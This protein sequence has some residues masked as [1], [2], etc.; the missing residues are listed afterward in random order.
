MTTKQAYEEIEKLHSEHHN[1]L[2]IALDE[3]VAASNKDDMGAVKGI[4]R[5]AHI[6]SGRIRF[7]AEKVMRSIEEEE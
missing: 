4:G 3:I 7:A 2:S 1:M 5:R 6:E